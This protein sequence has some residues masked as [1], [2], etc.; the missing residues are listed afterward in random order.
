MSRRLRDLQN[1]ILILSKT[2]FWIR[3]VRNL[4]KSAKSDMSGPAKT[5]PGG[6]IR[7]HMGPNPDRAFFASLRVCVPSGS[8][9]FSVGGIGFLV[10]VLI[11]VAP[12]IMLY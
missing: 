9:L 1:S 5:C 10:C 2:K 8:G 11:A 3:N 4:I 7:A 6:P 12:P